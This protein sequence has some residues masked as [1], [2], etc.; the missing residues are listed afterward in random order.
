VLRCVARRGIHLI[1]NSEKKTAFILI[2]FAVAFS[3]FAQEG[4]ETRFGSSCQ[5]HIKSSVYPSDLMDRTGKARVYVTLST[6]QGEPIADQE[7]VFEANCGTF[8]CK[9]M[10]SEDTASVDSSLYE[11]DHTDKN[12]RV[13]VYLVNIPFNNQG[14]VT[15]TCDYGSLSVKASCTFLISRYAL[16]SKRK[17]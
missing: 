7:I 12:G 5:M 10:D 11:C 8:S 9:P 4:D 16:K 15:A 14:S 13:M 2:W 1:L 3:V 6:K 17:N